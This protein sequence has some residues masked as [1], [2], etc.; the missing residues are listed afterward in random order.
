MPDDSLAI[1]VAQLY[2]TYRDGWFGRR[3]VEALKGVSFQVPR[4]QIF[5]LLGP[6][7]AGKT[8]LIKV[9]LGVV[10][11]SAGDAHLLGYRAG[12]RQGRRRVGYLPENHRIPRHHTGNSALDYYGSLS[13][14][15]RS[16]IRR[17]R[18]A[19]LEAVGLA[20]WG[21]V[22]VRKYSKG[23]QQR[24][25]LAQAMLHEP[26]LLI[27]DEPT[28]GVD[29]VG[30]SEMRA[31]LQ[32]LKEQGKTIFLNSHLLQEVELVCDRVA[33]LNKGELL[34]VGQI[35][36]LTL[37]PETEVVFTLQADEAAIR[38]VTQGW[39][40]AQFVGIGAGQFNVSLRVQGQAALDEC[41]DA[42]RR[43]QVSIV[44]IS[45]S[46]QTLEEAFLSII[47]QAGKGTSQL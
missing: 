2:K 18:P 39:N 14:L 7:G 10:R 35:S 44:A 32:G 9:L 36:D 19:L 30:R 1:D 41:I 4:G 34:R 29:P 47:T 23:M 5:G 25:G 40:V 45:R 27:L 6:N 42:L 33:I 46:R 12:D 43:R 8:T 13:G 28:D 24:L 26:E 15:P 17:R 22:S 31:L 3:R 16:E 20:E 37:R 38:S 11:R 21:K